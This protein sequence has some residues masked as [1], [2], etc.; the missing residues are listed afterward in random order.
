VASYVDNK[1]MPSLSGQAVWAQSFDSDYHVAETELRPIYNKPVTIG[2]DV[3]RNPAATIGQ[4]D[5]YGRLLVLHSVWAENMGIEKFLDEVLKPVLYDRFANQ[6]MFAV[7]DLAANQRSQIGE[8]SVLDVVRES[9]LNAVL[10]STNEIAPRLR[11][12]ESYMN[13]RNGLLICPVHCQDLIRAVRYGY[14]FKRSK[15][16]N[17][18]E[19]IPDKVHPDSDLGDSL[20]YLALGVES[21]TMAFHIRRSA[22]MHAPARPEPTHLAW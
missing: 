5:L 17:V 9:G 1:L 21:R 12:V 20:Q 16:T 19:E 6:A 11:A 18:L 8:K 10:A 15:N 22:A 7:L 2:M 3:G 4:I 13:R 14:R